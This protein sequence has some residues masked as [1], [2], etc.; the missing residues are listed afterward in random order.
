MITPRLPLVVLASLLACNAAAA[1][2]KKPAKK[3]APKKEKTWSML[4][5]HVMKKGGEW[6]MKA[7]ST[8]TLGYDS[9]LVAAKSLGIDQEKSA[10]NRE[11]NVFVVYEADEKG[12]LR[13]KE[14]VLANIRVIEKD[15]KEVIDAYRARAKLDGT[16]I[17]G[18]H[19]T[20][21]VGEVIQ[22]PLP[23]ESQELKS[24]FG[25]EKELYLKKMDWSQLTTE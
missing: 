24:V 5:D 22:T 14:V 2:A 15:G 4:I 12:K 18:M 25:T 16:L 3:S 21:A 6:P 17:R 8:R 11:H 7:P 10:D 9:D 20:G 19:S 1:D 13:A 23:P